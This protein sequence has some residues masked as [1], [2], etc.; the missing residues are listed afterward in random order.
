[1]K[2]KQEFY[3][4]FCFNEPLYQIL[5]KI[6]IYIFNLSL[7]LVFNALLYT[8]DQIYEGIKSLGKNIGNIFLRAFYTFLIIKVIDYLV[9]LLIKNANYLRSLVLR[10]RREKE[11]RVDAYKSL[12]NVQVI[13]ALF[14][15]FVIICDILF[16][17]YITSYCYCYN[18]EQWE[19]FGSILVTQFY[20]EI[21]CILFG[22]YL[23]VCRFIGLK[24]KATTFYKMSQT[25]LDN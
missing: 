24:Y 6:I 4:A 22:L 25:F 21:Y 23:A 14:I 8:E 3:R 9:N 11:I 2:A 18:G 20:M 7:S 12:K 19:L 17:I 10:R 13:F 5:I 1:M 15:I 16:W